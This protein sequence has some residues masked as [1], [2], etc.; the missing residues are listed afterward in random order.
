MMD[1]H[2]NEYIGLIS[3]LLA[4]AVA[5]L[6]YS[7]IL[8]NRWVTPDEGAHM[9]SAWRIHY[10]E[11][12]QA[13]YRS[14]Q[15]LYCYIH[16]FSQLFFGNTLFAGRIVSLLSTLF[17]GYLV[18]LIGRAVQNGV[19]GAV[20]AALFLF[21][22]LTIQ[23]A[24]VVQTQPLVMAFT[25]AAV[26]V[27][28]TRTGWWLVLSGALAACAFYIR[29]S[30]IAV[31]AAALVWI[32]FMRGGGRALLRQG[33]SFM[34]GYAGVVFLVVLIY[35]QWLSAAEIWHSTLNP[36]KLVID[37][38]NKFLPSAS[39]D[40]AISTGLAGTLEN[41]VKAGEKMSG[42][43]ASVVNL[44]LAA[45]FICF[46]LIAAAGTLI[47]R[48]RDRKMEDDESKFWFL[49]FW[50]AFLS[51]L[52][53]YWFMARGF[54]PGYLREFEPPLAILAATGL[55]EAVRRIGIRR[56]LVRS[57]PVIMLVLVSLAITMEKL[58]FWV[59]QFT[60]VVSVGFAVVILLCVGEVSWG[61]ARLPLV[62]AIVILGVLFIL[63]RV[64]GPLA[65]Q[66][67]GV[68][69]LAG[70]GLVLLAGML[71]RWA[72]VKNIG[73]RLLLG[74]TASGLAMSIFGVAE[75][76]GLDFHSY[77]PASTVI[78]VAGIIRENTDPDDE[79]MSAGVVWS[80][81][82]DRY[83]YMKNNHPLGFYRLDTDS[84]ETEDFYRYYLDNPP[85]IVV[86]DSMM[87]K[88]WY[89]STRLKAAIE[90]DYMPLDEAGPVG[91]VTV[92][93]HKSER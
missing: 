28:L 22:P 53:G 29:E 10:A 12:P 44:L 43:P 8:P 35:L 91:D 52:Y 82:A 61:K 75:K 4:I 87:E 38:I 90:N 37:A 34:A 9:M 60:L 31:A 21:S 77:W 59:E 20:A 55:V 36:F 65:G 49:L 48:L 57:F 1:T 74:A 11:V 58:P 3:A 7:W 40:S 2:R 24:T 83:P 15:P 88:T 41:H 16:A 72:D 5:A 80:Y 92:M 79:V 64:G 85:A 14:R 46:T 17:T 26:F 39:A 67:F 89:K 78:T 70:I 93:I 27:L 81:L 30:S 86:L 54:F 42:R 47:L 50:L 32:F 13:D 84:E 45:Q 66:P 73:S 76:G 56:I 33:L 25:C 51:I 68:N 18:F 6:F 62:V 19:V 23:Y 71:L 69:L 63:R